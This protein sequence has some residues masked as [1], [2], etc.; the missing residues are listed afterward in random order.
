[1]CLQGN[2]DQKLAHWWLYNVSSDN[3]APAVDIIIVHQSAACKHPLAGEKWRASVQT[4]S[5]GKKQKE[6]NKSKQRE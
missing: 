2:W 4:Q 1:M 5:A 3:T 6:Q